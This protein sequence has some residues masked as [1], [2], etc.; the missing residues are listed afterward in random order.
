VRAHVRLIFK[1]LEVR[2]PERAERQAPQH[3]EA[4]GAAGGRRAA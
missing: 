1:G 2:A 4:E 3:E